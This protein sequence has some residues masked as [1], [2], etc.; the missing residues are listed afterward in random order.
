MS[1]LREALGYVD[2]SEFWL[3]DKSRAEAYD[4]LAKLEGDYARGRADALRDTNDPVRVQDRK[5]AYACGYRDA[6][7]Y[8]KKGTKKP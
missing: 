8:V 1:T 7:D 4:E 6:L 2:W 5:D 3:R